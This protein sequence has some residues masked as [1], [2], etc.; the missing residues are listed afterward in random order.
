MNVTIVVDD[1]VL[2]RARVRAIRE[3]TSV[4]AV[5]RAYLAAYAGTDRC[6]D[7]PA[8]GCSRSRARPTR[9]AAV[10]FGAGTTFAT[11]E[12]CFVDTNVLNLPV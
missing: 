2:K 7:E 12:R 5:V 4:N 9:G 10:P 1:D 8:S 6:R 3:N 11:V